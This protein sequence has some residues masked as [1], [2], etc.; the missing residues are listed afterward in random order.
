MLHDN[1]PFE[2]TLINAPDELYD[3]IDE[4]KSKFL[5]KFKNIELIVQ[6][7]FEK[8]TKDVD[9][10]NR[11]DIAEYIATTAYPKLVFAMLDEKDYRSMIWRMLEPSKEL[12]FRLRKK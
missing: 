11:K 9:P 6:N 8:L 2:K 1:T 10:K 4:T 12:P 3:W 7:D 5:N